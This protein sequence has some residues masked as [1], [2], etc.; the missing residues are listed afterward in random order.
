MSLL[1]L[2]IIYEFDFTE[3]L[4]DNEDDIEE[5]NTYCINLRFFNQHIQ[6]F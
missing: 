5:Q 3:K 1:K 6:Y 2:N 4:L